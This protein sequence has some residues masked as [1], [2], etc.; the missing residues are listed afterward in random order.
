MFVSGVSCCSHRSSVLAFWR[1]TGGNTVPLYTVVTA[2]YVTCP[3]S[4]NENICCRT[5]GFS[6]SVFLLPLRLS[7]TISGEGIEGAGGI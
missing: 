3:I 2:P 1:A 4:T 5:E 7:N 6:F